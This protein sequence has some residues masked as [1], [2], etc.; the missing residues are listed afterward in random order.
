M[1]KW[2]EFYR[3]CNS[4]KTDTNLGKKSSKEPVLE[5][6]LWGK[7]TVINQDT[8][9]ASKEEGDGGNPEKSSQRVDKRRADID[10]L[11]CART[12][13]RQGSYACFQTRSK[14]S[15]LAEEPAL[16]N[17]NPAPVSGNLP[18]FNL[19]RFVLLFML[20]YPL[21]HANMQ[22]MH[23]PTN[24]APWHCTRCSEAVALQHMAQRKSKG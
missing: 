13:A 20:P 15:R 8:R 19:F 17:V 7:S 11:S 24:P 2:L 3:N 4:S 22:C 12:R 5:G 10:R 6:P 18:V 14:A 9:C 21:P 1:E 23:I 16:T